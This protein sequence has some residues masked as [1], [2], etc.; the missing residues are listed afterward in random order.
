MIKGIMWRLFAATLIVGSAAIMSVV[1]AMA[2]S[3]GMIGQS[4][5]AK[6]DSGVGYGAGMWGGHGHRVAYSRGW[7][8]H[9]WMNRGYGP[10]FGRMIGGYAWGPE[11]AGALELTNTQQKRIRG[12]Q[13]RLG[14]RKWAIMQAMHARMW[15][16]WHSY[17]KKDKIDVIVDT[18]KAMFDARLQILRS[19]LE[20]QKEIHAVL[21]QAQRKKL[22]EMERWGDGYRDY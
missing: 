9:D 21:N 6:T 2:Q 8:C 4:G 1:P 7:G 15:K 16:V 12:I 19:R 14:K 10:G 5:I 17:N 18:R 11:V 3:P 13:E 22:N 20:A